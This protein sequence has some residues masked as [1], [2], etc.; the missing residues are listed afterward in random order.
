M[1]YDKL[2]LY[3]RNCAFYELFFLKHIYLY[4]ADVCLFKNDLYFDKKLEL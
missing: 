2:I 1:K 4:I 3:H